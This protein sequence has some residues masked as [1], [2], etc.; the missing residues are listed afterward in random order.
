MLQNDVTMTLVQNSSTCRLGLGYHYHSGKDQE[1]KGFV[2]WQGY[3]KNWAHD[4]D[5]K[6]YKLLNGEEN[7]C[8]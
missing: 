3:C 1:Q 7:R 4:K 8:C 2:L 6:D 5:F